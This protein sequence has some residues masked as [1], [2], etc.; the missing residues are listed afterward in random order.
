MRHALLLGLAL[1]LAAPATAQMT[2]PAEAAAAPAGPEPAAAPPAPQKKK[3]RRSGLG[4]WFNLGANLSS[5]SDSAHNCPGHQAGLSV[6]RGL[7]LRV[8]YVKTS[9]EDSDRTDSCDGLFVGDSEISERSVLGGFMFGRSGWFFVG[10]P[11]AMN[12]EYDARFNRPRHGPHGR[13]T[14]TRYELGWNS[15]LRRGNGSGVEFALFMTE[16]EV[17]DLHG[18]AASFAFGLGR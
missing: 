2:V 11:S 7:M 17:R 6:A 10:G 5:V 8:E 15:G 13:D 3:A 18:F 14:G 16:T 9:Y 12:V 4:I 1:A